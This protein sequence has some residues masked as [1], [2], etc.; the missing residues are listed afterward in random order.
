MIKNVKIR[1][2]QFLAFITLLTNFSC[3]DSSSYDIIIVGGGTSGVV[4]AIQSS[5]MGSKT[6]LIEESNWLGGMM[7]S[8]GVSAMDG[9]YKLP[10]GFLKEF[11]DS[12]VSHYGH[13]DSLK[14][15]WVSNMMFEPSVGNQ[16]LKNIANSQKNLTIKYNS[17]VEGVQKNESFIVNLQ[18]GLNYESKVLI[19]ATELG[20]LIPMLN[21][22]YS[23]GMDSNKKYGEDIA[24]D[25]SNNIIQDLTYVMILKDFHKDMTIL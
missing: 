12:L 3:N 13:L 20:D 21:L 22:P 17:I 16:I 7:T 8:A 9:N 25:V 6:L 4:S 1:L 15:G 2:I 11:R 23:I 5:R 24:P 19:D 10:S 14:T 18:S